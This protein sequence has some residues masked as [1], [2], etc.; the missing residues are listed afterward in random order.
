MRLTVSG[1]QE[2]LQQENG[3]FTWT[4]PAGPA[5]SRSLLLQCDSPC[6]ISGMKLESDTGDFCAFL[7]EN[8]ERLG[9][10]MIFSGP[11]A[12]IKV[13]V[14]ENCAGKALQGTLWAAAFPEDHPLPGALM[15]AAAQ[16]KT[17]P[18]PAKEALLTSQPVFPDEGPVTDA[19]YRNLQALY[20][21]TTHSLSWRITAPL[22]KA[23]TL[24]RKLRNGG[25]T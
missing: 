21:Q 24:L 12:R 5:G 8:G 6:L 19:A 23:S 14:P 16:E 9:S 7:P 25:G 17:A 18:A 2:I 15:E 11:E 20:R 13:L 10:V 22:R 1:N 4:E 3:R